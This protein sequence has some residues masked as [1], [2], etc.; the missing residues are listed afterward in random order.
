[1][2]VV[3]AVLLLTGMLLAQIYL[4]PAPAPPAMYGRVVLDSHAARS[5]GPVVFDHWLHRSKFTCR[6]CHWM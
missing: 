6:L 3:V 5:P 2:L 1:V 4:P